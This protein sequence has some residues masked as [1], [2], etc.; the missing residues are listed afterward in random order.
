MRFI[1]YGFSG[2]GKTTKLKELKL[3]NNQTDYQYVDLDEYI[4]SLEPS[5]GRLG[6]LVED[7]G[8]SW[9]RNRELQVI[10][11]L[12]ERENIYIAL[13]GGS[14]SES[15]ISNLKQVDFKGI[16]LDVDF[17]TCWMRIKD[18]TNRPLVKLGPDQCLAIYNDRVK[19]FKQLEKL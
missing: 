18:D 17:E 2:S 12:L 16:Y 14:V 13:G 10:M 3:K 8:W 7:K 4:L 11:E 9:F 19:M 5:Y 6:S 15:L 1:I